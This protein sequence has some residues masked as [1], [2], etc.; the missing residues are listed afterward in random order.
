MVVPQPGGPK[1]RR[2][3]PE[4]VFDLSSPRKIQAD[5]GDV[6]DQ[7]FM[8]LSMKPRPNIL[9]EVG[10]GILL[11]ANAASSAS[12]TPL[13]VLPA[14]DPRSFATAVTPDGRYVIGYANSGSGSEA[15]RWSRAGGMV[16]LGNFPGG[17]LR[18]EAYAVSA[19]GG[20]VVGAA[21]PGSGTSFEPFHWTSAGGLTRLGGGLPAMFQGGGANGI[22]PD[23]LVVVGGVASSSGSIDAYRWTAVGGY[24][25]LGPLP[26]GAVGAN[27]TVVSADGRTVAGHLDLPGFEL[28]GFRWTAET[29]MVGLGR[30]VG[31]KAVQSE[32]YGMS[33][34]GRFITGLVAY[35]ETGNLEMMRWSA[36]EGMKPLGHFPEGENR[37]IGYGVS[38]DGRMVVGEA[39]MEVTDPSFPFPVRL[40][41]AAVWREGSGLKPL[42][43]LLVEGGVN[44]ASDGWE[45]LFIARA[46]SGDGRF[47][48]GSG[49]RNG[50][51]EAFIA[52]LA[53]RLEMTR[54]ASGLR[55]SWPVGFKLQR[56]GSLGAAAWT[57][58]LDAVSPWETSA[59]NG[60]AFFRLA[61]NP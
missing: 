36:A 10:L 58:V 20:T 41:R 9:V 28:E 3:S 54:T 26:A 15:F 22:T 45:F 49:R 50:K 53:P 42:W 12:L 2:S 43:D 55:L 61:A 27:S 40:P 38:D 24:S 56:T 21:F 4:G 5:F 30:E 60:P 48:V 25:L 32:I 37:S 14:L 13:G 57:D 35:Q 7:C 16:G 23:G 52:D 18:S 39:V 29:G 31:G 8:V 1:G 59:A 47:V 19:D 6:A 46:V 17:E 33:A 11:L 51:T 44:P 34:D